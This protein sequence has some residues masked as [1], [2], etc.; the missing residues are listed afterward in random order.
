MTLTH[1]MK[2]L[3]IFLSFWLLSCSE[4]QQTPLYSYE[5]TAQGAVAGAISPQGKL[6]AISSLTSG[7]L[8]W[9]LQNHQAKFRLSQQDPVNNVISHLRFSPDGQYLLTADAGNL[10]LWH[11][12]DGQNK[13]YWSSPDATIRDI[14][15][16]NEA[17]HVLIAQDDGKI[18]HIT[19]ASGRRL[20]FLGHSEKVNA[21]AMSPNGRYVLSG[22]NDL[23]AYLWD[24]QSG[25]I[26]H[27]FV[28]PTRITRVALDQQGQLAFTADS[29]QQA[30]VWDLKTGTPKW[31]LDMGRGRMFTAVRF[32][33][34]GR[35]LLTGGASRRVSIWDMQTGQLQQDFLVGLPQSYK[36]T[37]AVVYDIALISPEQ[38]FTVSSSGMAEVWTFIP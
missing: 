9:D 32:S 12:R 31:Q 11:M 35:Y 36:T 18:Q 24:S 15:L 1:R 7:I 29:Q 5:Y 30:T 22:S 21:V 10:S 23:K 25:Q 14:A 13:G 16:S 2:Y 28:H 34:D 38:L 20:E 8:V 3:S 33:D 4:V 19:L 27:T 26:I 37:S 6:S 17:R